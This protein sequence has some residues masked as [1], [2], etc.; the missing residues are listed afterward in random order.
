MG[1]IMSSVSAVSSTPQSKSHYEVLDGLRGVAALLVV[2]FH[3]LETNDHAI[4]FDQIWPSTS[5]S[6][7]PAS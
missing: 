5:S 2:A 7:S 4:R 1:A 3:I 6:C